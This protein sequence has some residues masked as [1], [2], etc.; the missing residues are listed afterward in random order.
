MLSPSTSFA[1]S[2]FGWLILPDLITAKALNF[3]HQLLPK[4]PPQRGTQLYTTH[5][6]ITYA[7]VVL[8]YLTYN[9]F[10]S[11]ASMPPNY[12]QMLGVGV[13]AEDSGLRTAYKAWVKRSHPDKMGG[14]ASAEAAFRVV[15]EG[16]EVLKDP[17][18]RSAYDR[19]VTTPK[20]R[21]SESHCSIQFWTRYPGVD[22]VYDLPRVS[23]ARTL[24]S[25]GLP[26]SHS[27]RT[28]W[29]RIDRST[30]RSHLRTL[31]TYL[32]FR[33]ALMPS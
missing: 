15:Q 26:H 9:L 10:T 18:R 28:D 20:C 13:N 5:Y 33:V 12:Y 2:F 31:L 14:S 6:R 4:P 25:F 30:Q 1:L 3:V 8:S 7:I 23:P 32:S 17:V 24:T 22:R 11:A 16:F 19:Y 29:A 21:I 27:C